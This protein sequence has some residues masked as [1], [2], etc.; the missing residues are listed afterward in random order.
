MLRITMPDYGIP[1]RVGVDWSR[2]AERFVGPAPVR[3]SDLVDP[4]MPLVEQ[5]GSAR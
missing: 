5:V 1:F 2:V 3:R 4:R